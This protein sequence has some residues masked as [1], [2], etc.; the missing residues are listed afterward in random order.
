MELELIPMEHFIYRVV[1]TMINEIE[2]ITV[3]ELSRTKLNAAQWFNVSLSFF[4]ALLA[5][6]S[7]K[8]NLEGE[9]GPDHQDGDEGNQVL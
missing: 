6:W 9:D 7:Q 3:L 5:V 1:E 4:L 2:V 8:S